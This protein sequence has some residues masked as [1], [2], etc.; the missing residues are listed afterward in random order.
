MGSRESNKGSKQLERHR[1]ENDKA[2]EIESTKQERLERRNLE[3]EKM[4]ELME[5]RQEAKALESQLRLV[6]MEQELQ[7]VRDRISRLKAQQN[8]PLYQTTSPSKNRHPNSPQ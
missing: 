5:A 6:K 8:S 4:R 2:F 7:E 1:L 3:I